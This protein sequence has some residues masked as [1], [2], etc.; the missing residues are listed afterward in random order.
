LQGLIPALPMCLRKIAILLHQ[1]RL[2]R[3]LPQAMVPTNLQEVDI[4]A[5]LMLAWWMVPFAL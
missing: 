5:G 2:A 3:M 1:T 4:R